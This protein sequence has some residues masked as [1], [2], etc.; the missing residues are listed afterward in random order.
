MASYYDSNYG[1]YDIQ[2]EE[3]VE[4]YHYVQRNS[5]WKNCGRCGERVKLRRDYGI[6]NSCADKIERGYDW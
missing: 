1:W 4:F 3:D 2:C 5:V 6:C